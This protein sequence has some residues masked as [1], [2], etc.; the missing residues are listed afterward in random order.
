MAEVSKPHLR[1]GISVPIA[2]EIKGYHTLVAMSQWSIDCYLI[3]GVSFV[4]PEPNKRKNTEQTPTEPPPKICIKVSDG[5]PPQNPKS[6]TPIKISLP[7]QSDEE[8]IP[9]EA[10]IRM[11]NL[12]RY[13]PTSCGPNSYGKGKYGFIDRRALLNRQTEALNEIVSDDN[14]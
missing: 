2:D 9:E 12:G 5:K 3:N 1:L 13:T 6:V 11:R 10:R 8:E 7:Q 4:V 14:R